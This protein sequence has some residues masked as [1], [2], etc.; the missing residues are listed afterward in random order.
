MNLKTF[1]NPKNWNFEQNYGRIFHFPEIGLFC[2]RMSI[3]FSLEKVFLFLLFAK[4]VYL[5]FKMLK[6]ISHQGSSINYV[7]LRQGRVSKILWRRNSNEALVLKSVKIFKKC[8]T[9]FMDDPLENIYIF[10]RREAT[11]TKQVTEDGELQ[12][13]LLCIHVS[14]FLYLS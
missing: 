11:S 14:S 1:F 3:D 9:S 12:K 10:D 7:T 6:E 5:T 13:T 2:G 4:K 8:E